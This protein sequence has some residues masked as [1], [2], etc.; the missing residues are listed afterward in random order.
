MRPDARLRDVFRENLALLEADGLITPWFDGQILPSAEWDTEIRRE[1]EDADVVVFLVST[2]FLSS[3]YIRGVEMVSALKRRAAGEAEL[4]A[5]ILE[6]DCAWKGRDFTRYQVLPPGVK[7]VRSWLRHAD[8]FNKV[9]Q[10]LRR[11]IEE[12]LA[13]PGTGVAGLTTSTRVM[14]GLR[15]QLGHG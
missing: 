12:M 4:V 3:R 15:Y 8:A 5:V 1:L 13:R 14:L 6:A 7:A 9:E 11:L 2:S 10:E